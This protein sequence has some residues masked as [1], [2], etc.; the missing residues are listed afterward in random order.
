M[1]DCTCPACNHAAV[2]PLDRSLWPPVYGAGVIV[3][4]DRTP[5]GDGIMIKP[6]NPLTDQFWAWDFEITGG[7]GYTS[8][9][10]AEGEWTPS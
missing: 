4:P 6:D 3:T 7:I 9:I 1:N 5:S 10:F 2:K 8:P